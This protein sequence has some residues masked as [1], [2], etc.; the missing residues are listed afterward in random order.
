MKDKI[1]KLCRSLFSKKCMSCPKPPKTTVPKTNPKWAPKDKVTH[2]GQKWDDD[3][4]RLCRFVN[5]PKI[6]NP[7][8]PLPFVCT[9]NNK[10]IYTTLRIVYCDGEGTHPRIFINMDKPHSIGYC[11]YCH[12]LFANSVKSKFTG[13]YC[14]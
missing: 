9:V 10:A 14:D 11:S 7:N 6:V 2:T 13:T 5:H 12:K 3:D 8:F 4:Y 1:V